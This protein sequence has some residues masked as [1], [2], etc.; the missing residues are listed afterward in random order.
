MRASGYEF[1]RVQVIPGVDRAVFQV[2]GAEVLTYEFGTDGPRPFVFPARGP[3]GN[4]LTR[5]GHPNPVGHEHHRSIW[6][7]HQNIQGVN[8][9]EEKP[10]SD[11]RIK[12]KKV[13]AYQDGPEWAGLAADLDWWAN[14]AS[15]MT[16]R[17]TL[18]L[19]L[20]PEGH[21]LDVQSRFESHGKPVELGKTNFGFLGVRVAKTLSEQFGGGVLTNS[22]G[23]T[24]EPA[25]FAKPARWVD[26]SGPSGPKT[27]EG[28]AY[29][30]HP[31]N[32]QHPTSWHV[33]RDGWM[34]ASF[35]LREAYGLAKDHPL[36]LRYRLLLHKG[37]ADPS[38]LNV[39]FDRFA[40]TPA[41]ELIT[42]KGTIPILR[43]KA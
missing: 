26:Y 10:N 25:I 36:D 19:S 7:G 42:T 28:I 23:A 18:S 34:C 33:R 43:P 24:G 11:V 6:F 38:L 17:L 14:G 13:L 4:V 30:D 12:H 22:E 35:N 15:V 29:L 20:Q 40:A 27:T 16:H 37:P 31:S 32:P 8:F 39:A 5:M 9:W 3:S 21:A 2:D 41:L 1:P